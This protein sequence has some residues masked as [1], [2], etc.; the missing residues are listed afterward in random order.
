MIKHTL[1]T[2]F[3]FN[4]KS[5]EDSSSS[6]TTHSPALDSGVTRNMSV[7]I[8]DITVA[9]LSSRRHSYKKATPPFLRMY[10]LFS[11]STKKK[12]KLV[13]YTKDLLGYDTKWQ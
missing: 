4:K 13:Y 12:S 2:D 11:K 8:A 7:V 3:D 9:S 10:D 1:I 5:D 6:I